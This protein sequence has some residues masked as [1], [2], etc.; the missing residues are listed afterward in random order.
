MER[1]GRSDEQVALEG[2]EKL[3]QLI[4]VAKLPT[5]FGESGYEITEEIARKVAENFDASEGSVH[6]LLKDE[7]VE[8]LMKCK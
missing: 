3:E 6:P 7:V 5:S 2:I 8:I 1:G 4:I